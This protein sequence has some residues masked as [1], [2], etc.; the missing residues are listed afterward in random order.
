[1]ENHDD[2]GSSHEI[3]SDEINYKCPHQKAFEADSWCRHLANACLHS[4]FI[5]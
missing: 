3:N 5:T 1:M 4:I 2:K